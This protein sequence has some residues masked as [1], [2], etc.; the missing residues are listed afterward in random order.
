MVTKKDV[1]KN[2]AGI[3]LRPSGIIMKAI[4]Q[5][6]GRVRLQSDSMAIEADSIMSIISLGLL[7]GDVVRIAVE[8]PKEREVADEL[9]EVFGTH[10]DFPP[11]E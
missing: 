6:G 9:A 7:E 5:Y 8:G 11:R 2:K 10:F 1:V 4:E 3:H